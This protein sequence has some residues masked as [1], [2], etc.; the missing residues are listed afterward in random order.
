MRNATARLLLDVRVDV[1]S[2]DILEVEI[3]RT[4][5]RFGLMK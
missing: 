5:K 3:H 2:D 1:V 4:A